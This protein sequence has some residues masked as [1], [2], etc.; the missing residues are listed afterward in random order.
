MSE[1]KETSNSI[2]KEEEETKTPAIN[3]ITLKSF[4]PMNVRKRPTTINIAQR[5]ILF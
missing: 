3:T 5:A 2:S 1:N 4:F